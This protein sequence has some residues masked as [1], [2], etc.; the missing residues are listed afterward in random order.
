MRPAVVQAL[1]EMPKVPEATA[2]WIELL[3][4]EGPSGGLKEEIE[5]ILRK[6]AGKD[7]GPRPQDWEAWHLSAR[8][9]D[10]KGSPYQG[11]V[12]EAG[13]GK[14]EWRILN[15]SQETQKL[16]LAFG[17][18]FR[19]TTEDG[20][21]L[22]LS[23][24]FEAPAARRGIKATLKPGQFVGGAADLKSLVDVKDARGPLRVTWSLKLEEG[25][26][27]LGRITSLPIRVE[28]K[29]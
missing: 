6:R 28:V 1:G 19:V 12:W 5:T 24:H 18:V 2:L 8:R 11:M 7:A 9:Q 10:K 16:D 13:P 3:A 14:I 26:G 25:E 22:P 21:E 20:K 23:V 27:D 15:I 4:E 29:K 17:P